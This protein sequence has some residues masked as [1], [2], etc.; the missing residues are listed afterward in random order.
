[1]RPPKE[2][3]KTKL[4]GTLTFRG[5]EAESNLQRRLRRSHQRGKW[6]TRR[7]TQQKPGGTGFQKDE[8][9]SRIG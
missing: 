6:E 3:A 8:V 1:M 7:G 9:R 4:Q 2:V 5:L